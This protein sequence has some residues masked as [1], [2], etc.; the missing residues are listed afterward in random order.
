MVTKAYRLEIVPDGKDSADTPPRYVQKP[1]AKLRDDITLD[2]AN[3]GTLLVWQEC[4]SSAGK[5]KNIILY[6]DD[7]PLPDV[8]AA[9]P[10]DPKSGSVMFPLQRTESSRNVWTYLLGKPSWKPR[11][12]RVS[13]GLEDQFGIE[14]QAILQLRVLPIGWF[15][16]WIAIFATLLLVLWRFARKTDVLRDGDA[17]IVQ[18]ARKPWSLSRVQGAWWFFLV[19][20]SYLFI[21]L[22][23]GDYSTSITGTTLV[24][25]GIA[26]GTAVTSVLVDRSKDTP[27]NAAMENAAKQRVATEISLLGAEIGAL[28]ARNAA[29]AGGGG[30]PDDPIQAAERS[31]IAQELEHKKAQLLGKQSQLRKLDRISEGFILDILSDANGV[32]FHR[33]QIATWTL[34]LGIIFGVQVFR[35]LGMPQF[36]ETLLGLMGLSAGTYVTLK[37][38]EPNTP[39]ATP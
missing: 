2:V 30:T 1:D 24:L 34:V 35:E 21:G 9:P 29:L 7:R 8:V 15:L 27:E 3:L 13:L 23:T 19:L 17:P 5:R 4:L 38:A 31:R 28:E 37:A 22:V 32:S 18:G 33:F 10:L 12:V 16:F 14:S 20:G 6:L 39:K 25:L 36:S 11:K 26:A